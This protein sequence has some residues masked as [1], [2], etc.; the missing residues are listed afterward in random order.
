M[1]CEIP[2]KRFEQREL[3][4]MTEWITLTHRLF[5][6]SEDAMMKFR[7]EREKFAEYRK[8]GSIA[9][10][11]CSAIFGRRTISFGLVQEYWNLLYTDGPSVNPIA[12]ASAGCVLPYGRLFHL[13]IRCWPVLD[14]TATNNDKRGLVDG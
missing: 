1:P 2:Q 14:N 10:D 5:W 9:V 7:K 12:N 13:Q 4:D 8:A 6:T 11:G 3:G